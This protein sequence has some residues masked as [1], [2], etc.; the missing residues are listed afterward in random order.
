MVHLMVSPSLLIFEFVSYFHKTQNL[1]L[2]PIAAASEGF[3]GLSPG[4]ASRWFSLGV[5]PFRAV[6]VD[7]LFTAL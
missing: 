1:R 5:A 7:I 4:P 6:F 3:A 2:C